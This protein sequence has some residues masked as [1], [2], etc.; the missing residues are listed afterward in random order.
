MQLVFWAV[1]E[2]DGL[3]LY[4]CWH[5]VTGIDFFDPTPKVPPKRR[6]FI[7]LYC[8]NVEVKTP[9]VKSIGGTHSVE[10]SLYDQ[11]GN[12]IWTQDPNDREQPDLAALNI[13]VPRLVDIVRIPITLDDEVASIVEFQKANIIT[14]LMVPPG[15]D[16][17]ILGY[18]YGYSSMGIKTPSPIFLKKSLASGM[19]EVAGRMLLDGGAAPG[20][21]GGPVITKKTDGTWGLIGIYTG[22]IFPDH[23]IGPEGRKNDKSAA[24]GMM[25]HLYVGRLLSLGIPA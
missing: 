23:L 17:V 7:K 25:V 10:V 2:D 11:Q 20:M 13:R 1:R 3:F 12:P 22:V 24:L 9:G 21:S 15:T 14:D 19:T 18:P 4:T 6:S 16:I 5:V 8:Q